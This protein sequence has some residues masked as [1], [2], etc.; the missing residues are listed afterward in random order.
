MMAFHA[1]RRFNR[2]GQW[3]CNLYSITTGQDAMIRQTATRASKRGVLKGLQ[4][5]LRQRVN[6][7][8]IRPP[9]WASAICRSSSAFL[10]IIRFN[11]GRQGLISRRTFSSRAMKFFTQ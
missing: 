3:M 5:M 2:N 10:K 9:F 7:G 1:S 6:G 8:G 4:G 11:P